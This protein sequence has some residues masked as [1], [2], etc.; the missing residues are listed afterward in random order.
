MI[1]DELTRYLYHIRF[2]ILVGAEGVRCCF[3]V[4]QVAGYL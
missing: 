4:A 1:Y 2:L 3:R